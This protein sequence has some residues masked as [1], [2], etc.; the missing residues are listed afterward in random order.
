MIC[1]RCGGNFEKVNYESV[2]LDRC[3]SCKGI[4]FDIFEVET[5]KKIKGS[6]EV[7]IGAGSDSLPDEEDDDGRDLICP[8]CQTQMTHMADTYDADL[9]YH[10]C[11]V[12][13]GVWFDA[14]KFRHYREHGLLRS[15]KRLISR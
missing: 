12:C 5:L 6:A 1:P 13:Y 9:F 11:P 8:N 2:I 10:K 15:I 7:D 14:G 4:W 3:A